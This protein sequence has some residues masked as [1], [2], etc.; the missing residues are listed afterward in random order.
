[1]E[2]L[3][4]DY[5]EVWVPSAIKPL[6]RFADHVRGIADTG[7]DLVGITDSPALPELSRFDEIVSW[8]GEN[9]EDFRD[10][11]AHLP[12]RFFPA[13]PP[14]LGDPHIDVPAVRRTK[15]VVHP[16]SASPN[17]NWP[18][19]KFEELAAR[20]GAEFAVRRDGSPLIED[21]YE[22]A[23]WLAHA[24]IYIGNDS[25]I[26]HLAAAVGTP[27]VA[28]F[29]PMDPAIWAPRTPRSAVIRRQPMDLITVDEVIAAVD[30]LLCAD[31]ANGASKGQ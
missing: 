2:A 26:T 14:P 6:V 20:L 23:C 5:T 28:L 8:Y 12:F 16:F 19:A 24:K 22:L 15:I 7:L 17:K 21:L 27:V 13:L 31:G 4:A 10:A 29:G 3:R 25:G 18:L 11:V 30:R 9:R 1:M